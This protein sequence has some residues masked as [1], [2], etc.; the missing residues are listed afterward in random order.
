M[1]LQ[2]GFEFKTRQASAT[3]NGIVVAKEY[4][5]AVEAVMQGLIDEQNEEQEFKESVEAFKRQRR[6]LME[7]KIRERL[8]ILPADTKAETEERSVP[9]EG[10]QKEKEVDEG[11][12]IGGGF[13]TERNDGN[14]NNGGGFFTEEGGDSNDVNGSGDGDEGGGFIPEDEEG[15]G[16]GGFLPEEGQSEED[17]S[18]MEILEDPEDEDLGWF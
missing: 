15:D 1:L 9:K 16:G 8:G 5:E 13:S 17:K 4:Q 12:D 11:K 3:I 18:D 14:D 7:L 2:T 6:L 10:N